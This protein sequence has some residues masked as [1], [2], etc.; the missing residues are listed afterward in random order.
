MESDP[1]TPNGTNIKLTLVE[2]AL[3]DQQCAL[4]G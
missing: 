1:P 4:L 2:E 3:L